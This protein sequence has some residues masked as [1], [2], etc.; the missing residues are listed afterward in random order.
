MVSAT[1]KNGE[2]KILKETMQY[3]RD[4]RNDKLIASDWTQMSDSPLSESKKQEWATYRQQLRDLP[5]SY[6]DDNE[7]SDIVWPTKPE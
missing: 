5:V 7:W 1:F 2:V 3:L 4:K 6:T